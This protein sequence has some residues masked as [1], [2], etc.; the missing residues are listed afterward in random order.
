M[1]TEAEPLKTEAER[2][3]AASAIR[4]MWERANRPLKTEAEQAEAARAIALNKVL[5]ADWEW[6][7]RPWW[8][9]VWRSGR[10]EPTALG[11]KERL[12]PSA[13]IHS[14]QDGLGFRNLASSMGRSRERSSSGA[15]KPKQVSSG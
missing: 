6:A 2:A 11:A 7:N 15:S 8:R 5:A 13:A 9:R 14:K 1:K 10:I 3:K 4:E 12:G